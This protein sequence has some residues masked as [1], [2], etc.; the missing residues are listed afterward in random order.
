MASVQNCGRLGLLRTT[1]IGRPLQLAEVAENL[2]V[3][4][5]IMP[6]RNSLSAAR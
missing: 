6:L 2:D 3:G 4:R 5:T 1:R